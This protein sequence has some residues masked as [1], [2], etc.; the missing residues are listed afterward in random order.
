MCTGATDRPT[1]T[2]GQRGAR[3]PSIDAS[4]RISDSDSDP[5]SVEKFAA[6]EQ[7]HQKDDHD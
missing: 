7:Q 4:W 6:A 2:G 3:E 5:T 1:A